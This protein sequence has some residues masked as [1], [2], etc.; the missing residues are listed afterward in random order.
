MHRKSGLVLITYKT[1]GK[2]ILK[3]LFPLF[4]ILCS[5]NPLALPQTTNQQ[6]V[7]IRMSSAYTSFPDTGRANGHVYEGAVYDAKTHY[8]DSSVIMVIPPG[9]KSSKKTDFVFWF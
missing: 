8:S 2:I 3:K 6:P 5:C 9:F 7:I 1:V 4:L